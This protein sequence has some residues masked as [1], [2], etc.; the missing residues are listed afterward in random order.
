MG[1]TN[2][3][4]NNNV[5]LDFTSAIGPFTALSFTY[6]DMQP[7]SGNYDGSVVSR[8][9][10][11]GQTINLTANSNPQ[12]VSWSGGAVSSF[13]ILTTNDQWGLDEMSFTPA[14]QTL[15]T[16]NSNTL[17][18]TPL[19]QG[20]LSAALSAGQTL[21]V[22]DGATRLGAATVSGTSWSY[23]VA[24]ASAST[25]NYVAKVVN[26]S[27]VV[28]G[29]SN[30]F[31]LN[32]KTSPL[33]LD[34]NG[35][36]VQTTSLSAGASFDIDGNGTT[37][38]VAWVNAHDGLLVRDL[39]GN[40]SI[41]NGAELFG[42]STLLPDGTKAQDGWA[43]LAALD[44]N[45]DGNV[46]AQDAAF[47]QLR[48][49]QDANGNGVTDAGELKSLSDLGIASVN[50]GHDNRSVEQNGNTLQ[51]FGSFTTTDGATHQVADAWLQSTTNSYAI[52]DN[53]VLTLLDNHAPLD[54]S[55]VTG[56][57]AL[58]EVN[59]SA[60]ASANVVKLSLADLLAQPAGANHQLKLTGDSNDTVALDL[61]N[62]TNTGTTV[63]ENGHTYAVY[64]ANALSSEQ[65]L[66]DQHMLVTQHS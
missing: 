36:G 18:N 51:G 63:T 58:T 56:A 62:W 41:D 45:G 57:N 14:S 15:S 44:S 19:L 35:D 8:L 42:N 59:A 52:S 5:R 10:I 53:G 37:E 61:A 2:D 32:V 23:Q 6:S 43:A 39:N 28:V 50:T 64:N 54:L 65:L 25:H 38:H 31:V 17:D 30:T 46:D 21:D 55:K 4:G 66:I 40:G 12:T 22:Y 49:W 48:V 47:G 16:S 27:S 3:K 34:L 20:T 33:V 60:D 7:S 29:S 9:V 24:S 1:T 26:S 11:N 13:Y